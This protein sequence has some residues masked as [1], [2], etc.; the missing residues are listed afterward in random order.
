MRGLGMRR[1]SGGRG[2]VCENWA[3][4][5]G[6]EKLNTCE[7]EVSS[8]SMALLRMLLARWANFRVDSVS[9]SATSTGLIAAMRH[10]FELPG[11]T[12]RT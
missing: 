7:P 2:D 3:K 9:D 10:V 5:V 1:R 8:L 4:E 12:G 6:H 11:V